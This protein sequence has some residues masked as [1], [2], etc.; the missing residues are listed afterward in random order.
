V[1]NEVRRQRFEREARAVSVLSHPNICALY[2][3]GEQD[4]VPFL[5]MEFVEGDSLASRLHRGPLPLKDVQRIGLEVADALDHAHRQHIVHRDL[6]PA[7]IMLSPTGAKLLDF[8]L[9][10]LTDADVAHAA[11]TAVHRV[12]TLTEEGAIVGTIQYMAPEQ[13]EGG[14]IDARTD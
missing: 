13:L 11:S 7:N 1:T 8:G 3:V 14:T 12:D 4:G 6:K 5:V 10:R 9:A 2:D